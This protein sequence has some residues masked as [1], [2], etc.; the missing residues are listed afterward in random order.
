MMSF[1]MMSFVPWA[2]QCARCTSMCRCHHDRCYD[3]NLTYRHTPKQLLCTSL[4]ASV[5]HRAWHVESHC[6]GYASSTH[7]VPRSELMS[8]AR[9]CAAMSRCNEIHI[10]G[11]VEAAT[12]LSARRW[13]VRPVRCEGWA[14]V[15]QHDITN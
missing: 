10:G 8:H 3:M 13:Y 1:V 9:T 5:D 14:G 15:I 12:G 7:R 4:R 2:W 11:S 6:C